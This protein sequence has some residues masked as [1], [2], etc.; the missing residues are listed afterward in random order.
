M[1][2][3]VRYEAIC[4]DITHGL[5]LY[6]SVDRPVPLFR[7]FLFLPCESLLDKKPSLVSCVEGFD[8]SSSKGYGECDDIDL[9]RDIV[10]QRNI[11]TE[12]DW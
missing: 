5:I 6:F 1:L 2:Q 12:E 9:D 7:L 3:V 4:S 10:E 8:T 11:E